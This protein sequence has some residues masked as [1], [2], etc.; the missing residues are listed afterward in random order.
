M[1]GKVQHNHYF[2]VVNGLKDIDVYRVI[3]LFNI[4]D[5]CIQHALKKLL[6][7]GGRGAGKDIT[8]DL[9]EVIDSLE[10]W[11]EMREEDKAM[12]IALL[13]LP[14]VGFP[15][16]DVS[17]AKVLLSES[18]TAHLAHGLD[19]TKALV[20]HSKNAGCMNPAACMSQSRCAQK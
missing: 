16:L 10:R 12:E 19:H 4:T 8:K 18:K 2:K 5:P 6:V 9:Q 14:P 13:S 15:D 17:D 11:K 20:C 7:A 1:A 3:R